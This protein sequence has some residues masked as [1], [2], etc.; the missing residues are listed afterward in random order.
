MTSLIAR[1]DSQHIG[2]TTS[3]KVAEHKNIAESIK[4]K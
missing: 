1:Q 2:H 3:K 4:L